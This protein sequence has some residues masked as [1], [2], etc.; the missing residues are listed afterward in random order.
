MKFAYIDVETSG[1]DPRKNAVLQLAGTLEDDSRSENFNYFIKPFPTDIVDA[2][3]LEVNKL[4]PNEEKFKEPRFVYDDFTYMLSTFVNKFDKKD[5]MFFVGYNSHFFDMPFVREFFSKCGN[6]YFGSYFFFPSL[7]I[8]VMAQFKLMKQRH[9]MKDF[10][11][12][13]VAKELGITVEE[14]QLHDAMYDIRLTKEI[15]LKLKD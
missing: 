2:K 13:T 8:M 9:L 7:D 3:A 14:E 4:N 12:H 15:F 11:L 1:L 10:K 6:K 5:K